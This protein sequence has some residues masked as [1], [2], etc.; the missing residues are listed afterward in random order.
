MSDHS[1]LIGIRSGR[2]EIIKNVG[3]FDTPKK[4]WHVLCRCDCGTLKI[5]R[6]SRVT[7]KTDTS[8]GCNR[9]RPTHRR[10]KSDPTYACWA[11]MIQRC[12]N[13][14]R[15][16]YKWYGKRG[17]TVCDRWRDF[18]KFVEDM[19]ERP[20]GKTLE[21]INNDGNYCPDNCR[22]ATFHEQALN[23]RPRNSV[24]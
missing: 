5:V 7:L 14:K 13:P 16:D 22:W 1:K 9:G 21:R 12:Q 23:R 24:H 20:E 15:R 18:L 8:C 17:I 10:K 11:N 6:A 19:G 3:T 4:H 2:L